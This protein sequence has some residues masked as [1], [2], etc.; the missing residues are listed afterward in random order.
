MCVYLVV[1]WVDVLRGAGVGEK[2]VEELQNRTKRAKQTAA[3]GK[4]ILPP[5]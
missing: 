5:I 4:L 1:C 3:F 2:E